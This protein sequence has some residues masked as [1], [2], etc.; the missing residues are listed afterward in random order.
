MQ[1]YCF[2]LAWSFKTDRGS[3]VSLG[4]CLFLL[5]QK[6]WRDLTAL[7]AVF[8]GIGNSNASPWNSRVPIRYSSSLR[9]LSGNSV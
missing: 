6:R 3:G 5:L 7:T 9:G 1:A 8:C 2:Y 4:V